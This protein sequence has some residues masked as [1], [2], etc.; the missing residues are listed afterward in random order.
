MTTLILDQR[1]QQSALDRRGGAVLY[2]VDG[3]SDADVVASVLPTDVAL[4]LVAQP[5]FPANLVLVLTDGDSSVGSMTATIVGFDENDDAQTAVETFAGG[6]TETII[7]SER[8]TVITSITLATSTGASGADRIKVGTALGA[9]QDFSFPRPGIW[10]GVAAA[11]DDWIRRGPI[12]HLRVSYHHVGGSTDAGGLNVQESLDGS[13]VDST[14][15]QVTAISDGYVQKVVEL[16][17]P[18]FRFN[19]DG[20]ATAQ[21]RLDLRVVALVADPFEAGRVAGKTQVVEVPI[22]AAAN[23]GVTTVATVTDQPCVIESVV[24]HADAAQTGDLTTAAVEGGASQVVEFIGTG[25][26]TQGNLDAADK[27][28]AWTGAVR[29]AA[30]KAVTVDLQGSGATAVDLTVTITYRAAADGGYLA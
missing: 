27:Q 26:A 7:T 4:A 12:T 29:L 8:W 28:V 20:D 25:D 30:G 10:N 23:A 21:T 1:L 6:G 17:A 15:W 5:S 3:A 9:G 19:A 14:P 16:S 22:T 18:Y 13:T 24:L 11:Q 2:S